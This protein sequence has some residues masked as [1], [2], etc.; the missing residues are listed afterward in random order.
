MERFVILI[1]ALGLWSGCGGGNGDAQGEPPKPT[2]TVATPLKERITEWQVFTGRLDSVSDV[3]IRARVSGYLEKVHFKDGEIVQKGDL[4]FTID[5]RPFRAE[6]AR[7]EASVAQSEAALRLAESNLVRAQQLIEA[8]AISRQDFDLRQSEAE[9]AAANVQAARAQLTQAELDLSYTEIHAP[10][11]GV[12]GAHEVTEGNLISGGAVGSTLLTTI[13]PHRPIYAYFEID[14]ASALANVRRV[15]AGK[16]PGRGE[17]NGG[18]PIEMQLRDETGFPHR[19][20]FDFVDNR[21]D[22]ET[23]TLRARA[24]FENEDRFLTP[25]LFV[26]VR[27]QVSDE[28]EAILIPDQAVGTLQSKSYVWVIGEDGIAERQ[29]IR[30]GPLHEGMRIVR[31]GLDGSE[32]VAIAGLQMIRPGSP[33][34]VEEESI[35]LTRTSEESTSEPGS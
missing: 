7:A 31:E 29:T 2:V 25:G 9:Q 6:V 17:A 1:A 33:V 26:R 18:M 3:E 19:G 14:E 21:L 34:N 10:I 24:R 23:A 30:T 11:Q 22:R 12:A 15:M 16:M 27:M 32:R 8:N 28:Y 20:V 35:S 5:Q 4:L 13:V